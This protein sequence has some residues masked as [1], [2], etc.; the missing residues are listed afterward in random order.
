MQQPLPVAT[1]P[2]E[3]DAIVAYNRRL[4]Q[5]CR[6]RTGPVFDHVDTA[7]AVRDL[8]AIRAALGESRLSYYGVSYGTLIGQQYAE[9][10]PPSYGMGIW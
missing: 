2:A 8:D 10:F 3:F 7:S 1:S 4:G 9:R 5:D 6:Q